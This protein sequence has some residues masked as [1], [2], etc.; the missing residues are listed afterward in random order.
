[1][2]GGRGRG[3]GS[4]E[5]RERSQKEWYTRGSAKRSHKRT[6]YYKANF[7]ML[8]NKPWEDIYEQ[9]KKDH[10]TKKQSKRRADR[11]EDTCWRIERKE[12][13]WS[14][15][16]RHSLL[17]DDGLSCGA[18]EADEDELRHSLLD[19]ALS[20]QY[21]LKDLKSYRANMKFYLLWRNRKT[22]KSYRSPVKDRLEDKK[23]IARTIK[24]Y[25]PKRTPSAKQSIFLRYR[26]NGNYSRRAFQIRKPPLHGMPK[27]DAKVQLSRPGPSDA[28]GPKPMRITRPGVSAN[29]APMVRFPRPSGHLPMRPPVY[30]MPP[31]LP[32][33]LSAQPRPSPPNRRTDSSKSSESFP[34]RSNAVSPRPNRSLPIS[35][36]PR[37][38]RTFPSSP[39]PMGM[40]G[41]YPMP[42]GTV[43]P[44]PMPMGTVIPYPMPMG[45]VIPY[46][47]PLGTVIPS[48][49]SDSFFSVDSENTAIASST[50]T[51]HDATPWD[52]PVHLPEGEGTPEPVGELTE[53]PFDNLPTS[54]QPDAEMLDLSRP[55][56]E[57]QWWRKPAVAS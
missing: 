20:L 33:S 48:M 28:R 6:A 37:M 49:L 40:V 43:I 17:T 51:W 1:M 19:N 54:S 15:E 29:G 41:P 14:F 34:S 16:H 21:K 18:M 52:E 11:V 56:F 22:S 55:T 30:A 5:E 12:K 36:E 4:Y 7:G 39:L 10:Y 50:A 27:N 3:R 38:P 8:L 53:A 35:R 45:T 31:V 24:A 57:S 26:V 46:P 47:M 32:M 23:A 13:Q 25:M 9:E 42:M 2:L 44:Y